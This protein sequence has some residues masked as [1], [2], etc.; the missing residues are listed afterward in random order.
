[1][2]ASRVFAKSITFFVIGPAESQCVE[3]GTIPCCETRPI[4]GFIVYSEALFAGMIRLPEVSDPIEIG[5]KPALTATPDP[6]DEPPQ[7]CY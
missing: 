5:A 6:E 2:S 7:F 1:M 4:V 3:A